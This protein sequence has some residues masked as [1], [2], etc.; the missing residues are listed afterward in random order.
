MEYLRD[1][2]KGCAWD[3]KQTFSSI[4][5]YTIEEAYEVAQAI[6]DENLTPV[7][8]PSIDIEKYDEGNDLKASLSLEVMPIIKHIDLSK[9]K[10]DKPIA[11]VED[12]DILRQ[13]IA[14]GE[15]RSLV[16]ELQFQAY[17]LM[18]EFQQRK[19]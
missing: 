5:P 17:N 4:S 11:K 8:K 1:P 16:K 2:E 15:L 19:I 3:I 18:W 7:T 13:V 9:V 6:Q 14:G 10:L 12:K